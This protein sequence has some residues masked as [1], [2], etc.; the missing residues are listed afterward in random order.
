MK[1]IAK[2]IPSNP[3]GDW[4]GLSFGENR[5]PRINVHAPLSDFFAKFTWGSGF[6]F[7][8]RVTAPIKPSRSK[9]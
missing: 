5:P 2:K 4:L 9:G 8:P 7:D 6:F 1:K 3:C